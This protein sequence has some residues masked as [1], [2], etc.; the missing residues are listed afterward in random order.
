MYHPKR[1]YLLYN[2]FVKKWWGSALAILAIIAGY[3]CYCLVRPLQIGAAKIQLPELT[4]GKLSATNLGLRRAAIGY[5]NPEDNAIQC[6]AL[7]DGE[8]YTTPI[9][10]A[11]LAK[12]ITVQVV[13][14]KYPLKAGESG[15]TITMTND[16]ESRYW[17]AVN[18]GGSN[19]RVVAGEQIT[20]RQLLEGILLVSANNMA[21]SLAIWA[22]GSIDGYHQAAR[23]WLDKNNLVSTIVG[24]DASGFSSETKSTPTDLCKIMLLATKQPALVEIL[25]A[26]TATLPTGEVLQSTNRLLGQ[27]GIFAGKTGYTDEAGRGLM[28]ASHQQ[29]GNVQ[30][31]TAAVSLSNDSYDAAFDTTNQL[32]LTL[33]NDLQVYS[34]SKGEPIGEVG[35][36][37][38]SQ[39]DLSVNHT[40]VIP[41]WSDQPPTIKLSLNKQITDSLSPNTIIGTLQIG[42]NYINVHATSGIEPARLAWRLTTPINPT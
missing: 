15:P 1:A 23:Q 18:N 41:Y 25:S 40:V 33:A 30:L 39:T 19:A 9:A 22:F 35:S 24:G 29:I 42:A 11:S 16:D 21:D 17:W 6:R 10:T 5:I 32:V 28:V 14:D 26:N 27:N 7:G 36:L 13:L 8:A 2:G 20:E 37:W 31:T 34:I 3:V 4:S 38:G 12:M